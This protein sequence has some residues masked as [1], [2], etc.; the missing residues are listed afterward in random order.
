VV[1]WWHGVPPERI[2]SDPLG[3]VA[4]RRITDVAQS[5]DPFAGLL[6]RAEDYS[7][8]DTDLAWTRT[9]PWRT[10]IAG[11]FD[12]A[13]EVTV[14]A[15]SVQAPPDDPVAVLLAGWLSARL[16]LTPEMVP[17]DKRHLEKVMLSLSDGTQ[18]S[19]TRQG[20]TAV[21]SRTDHADR[22]LPLVPRR[23]GEELAE[24]LHR[25][26]ADQ[27]YAQALSVAMGISGIDKRPA[28]RSL[29][30]SKQKAAS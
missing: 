19:L 11:A 24:E 22:I 4:E 21:M 15:F 2:E 13:S 8:G 16:G 6:Q 29:R 3:V 9:T 26:D 10:L 28:T 20:G 25:L 17:S 14:R 12:T 27:P 5:K 1:T 30:T 18:M 7:P 23:L